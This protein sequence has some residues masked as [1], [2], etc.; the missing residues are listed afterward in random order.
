MARI[1]RVEARTVVVPLASPT[2][3]STRSVVARHY[4]VVRT[5]D[6]DG[7]E[8][9]G[10]TYAG[11]SGGS[12]VTIAVRELVAPMVVG[13]HSWRVR[14][15][16]D[17]IY[18]DT[19][20]HGRAGSVMRALSA[21]DIALWDLNARIAN[22]PLWQYLGACAKTSVAAYASGGYYLDGKSPEDLGREMRSYVDLGFSAVKL[23]VGR[24]SPAGDEERVAAVRDAVGKDVLVMLDANNAWRDLP[25]ALRHLRPLEQHDPYF[26]EEPFGPDD[27]ANHARLRQ[28]TPITVATGEIEQGR[29]RHKSWL[30]AEAVAILQTDAAVCGG[31]TEYQRIAAIADSYGV[32]MA[33][34]WFHDLHAH[35]VAATSNA[36]FVEFFPDDRVLNFRK[37]IDHQ[38]SINADGSLALPESPGLGFNFIAEELDRLSEDLWR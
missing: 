31:I 29:W 38:L 8:G 17:D 28:E 35:L 2:S 22:Q 18:Q 13:D 14:G 24:L 26:I 30:D 12:V 5:T 4:T 27:I 1:E 15:L 6:A 23:K 21:V 32:S 36:H 11:S 34:H 37:L 9:I 3:F 7:I 33:P 25:T 16:W 10:F 19:L 20:L